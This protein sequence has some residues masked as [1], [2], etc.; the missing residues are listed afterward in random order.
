MG[1][2]FYNST[3]RR[4]VIGGYRAVQRHLCA[5][6][7]FFP[8]SIRAANGTWQ[9]TSSGGAM[10]VK[11]CP[12]RVRVTDQNEVCFA[13]SHRAAS[14]GRRWQTLLQPPSTASRHA[15]CRFHHHT[16][17]AG[18]VG[19]RAELHTA[20]GWA[21]GPSPA[22]Q[23]AAPPVRRQLTAAST[24]NVGVTRRP[25]IARLSRCPATRVASVT[26]FVSGR[27]WCV[28]GPE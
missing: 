17:F 4:P 12:E 3:T 1:T 24:R 28:R 9:C 18:V 14:P 6:S 13:S 27:N 19:T 26:S 7:R 22:R 2:T 10:Q 21:V 23:P 8:I 16:D 5:L 25:S 20:L 15:L 11:K